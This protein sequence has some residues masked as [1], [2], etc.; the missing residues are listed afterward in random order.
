MYAVSAFEEQFLKLEKVI[1][2][3]FCNEYRKTKA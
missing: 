1:H 3:T 2:T